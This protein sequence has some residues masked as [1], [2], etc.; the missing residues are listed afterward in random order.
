LDR[1]YCENLDAVTF[2][3][4]LTNAVRIQADVNSI[5]YDKEDAL[6]LAVNF[7]NPPGRLLRRQWTCPLRVVPDMDAWR[8]HDK[9]SLLLKEN[10]LN[11]P[12]YKVGHIR[13]N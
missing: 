5:Y 9:S 2:R 10:L 13:T 12:Y 6:L 8:A 7:K 11:I 4:V 3:Q 1:N